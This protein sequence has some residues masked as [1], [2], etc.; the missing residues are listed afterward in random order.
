MNETDPRPDNAEPRPETDPRTEPNPRPETDPRSADESPLPANKP[1]GGAKK[2]AAERVDRALSVLAFIFG[3]F[4]FLVFGT[5]FVKITVF[6]EGTL[7]VVACVLVFAG[8]LIPLLF[9]RQFRKL[10]KKLYVPAKAIYTFVLAAFCVS[11]IAFCVFIFAGGEET[12]YEELPD[13]TVV[14]V[15]GAKVKATGSPGTPLARRLHKAKEIL[16]ARPD[17]VCVVSGGKGDDEPTS[18]AEAME[19]WLTTAGVDE[20]RI[21]VEDRSHNTL[22]NIEYSRE[23]IE[24]NGLSDRAVACV[25]SDFH[26]ARIRYISE[27]TGGFGDYYYRAGGLRRFDWEYFGIA[28]EYLS[29]ARLL[30]LGTES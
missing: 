21:F 6:P 8:L 2:P 20:S 12:P 25:S 24:E 7:P 13:N 5:Y 30:I 28:R 3:A 1:D 10:L 14:V 9:R 17:T 22:E 15:F 16:D 26:V 18:E 23:L 11:F 27:R 19:T 4:T 29:F